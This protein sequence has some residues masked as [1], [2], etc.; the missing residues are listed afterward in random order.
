[1]L[2]SELNNKVGLTITN[3]ALQLCSLAEIEGFSPS[4]QPNLQFILPSQLRH[5]LYAIGFKN[6]ITMHVNIQNHR[7]LAII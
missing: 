2:E 4:P 1:M 6:L 7:L 3:T 5:Q